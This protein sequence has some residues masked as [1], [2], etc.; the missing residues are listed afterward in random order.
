MADDEGLHREKQCAFRYGRVET[1]D[2]RSVAKRDG[3]IPKWDDRAFLRARSGDERR[4]DFVVRAREWRVESA[5]GAGVR[6]GD[7][8]QGVDRF[9]ERVP[10]RSPRTDRVFQSGAWTRQSGRPVCVGD[11]VQSPRPVCA[12]YQRTVLQ[13]SRAWTRRARGGAAGAASGEA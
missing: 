4:R 12:E 1:C 2:A 8:R 13:L 11:A 5:G 6:A 3:E 9:P 10:V 7:Q